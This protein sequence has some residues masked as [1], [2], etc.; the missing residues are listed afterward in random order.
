M[1]KPQPEAVELTEADIAALVDRAMDGEDSIDRLASDAIWPNGM[2]RRSDQWPAHAWDSYLTAA[3]LYAELRL[4]DRKEL[5]I[6]P[7]AAWVAV[8]ASAVHQVIARRLTWGD[9]SARLGA[10]AR[11]AQYRLTRMGFIFGGAAGRRS[12]STGPCICCGTPQ[13]YPS[14]L[15]FV[16]VCCRS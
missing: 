4:L 5:E 11:V 2:P 13:E 14:L 10:S 6:A 3:R 1:R 12:I 15:D 8:A 9:I 16:G 7:Q